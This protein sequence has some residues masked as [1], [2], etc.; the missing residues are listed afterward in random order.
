MNILKAS[1]LLVILLKY[2]I[3][4]ESDVNEDV[5]K[6]LEE[7]GFVSIK[8]DWNHWEY[9]KDLFDHVVMKEY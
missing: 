5:I 1:I 4:S 3:A 6:V 2:V 7:D 9:R 8:R